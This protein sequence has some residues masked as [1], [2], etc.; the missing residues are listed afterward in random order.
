[1]SFGWSFG[2]IGHV[3]QL[4]H[5]FRSTSR[6]FD[7]TSFNQNL[8]SW[9][10]LLLDD[11]V[12]FAAFSSASGCPVQTDPFWTGLEYNALCQACVITNNAQLQAEIGTWIDSGNSAFGD[13]SNWD[14][15]RVDDFSF[16]F[17]GKSTFNDDISLWDTVQVTRMDSM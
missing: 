9:N 10:P 3:T 14:V 2:R 7:A 8:C 12:F 13:I 17:T 1:M 16:L 11:S 15:S 5:C 6:F 4:S